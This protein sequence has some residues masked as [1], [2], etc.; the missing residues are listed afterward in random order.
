M[1]AGNLHVKTAYDEACADFEAFVAAGNAEAIDPKEAL[2]LIRSEA[3]VIRA[4]NN[5]A[6]ATWIVC[7][8]DGYILCDT[9]RS[10][11]Q[12]FSTE[13]RAIKRARE[14]VAN[15]EDQEAWIFRLSHI[16]SRPDTEATVEKVK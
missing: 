3:H 10:K 15:S 6:K 5:M 12:E 8:M 9:N 16:V 7:G 1:A 13:A 11:P 14:W 4:R 2:R